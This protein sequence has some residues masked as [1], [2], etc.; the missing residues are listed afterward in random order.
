MIDNYL[1]RN[2]TPLGVVTKR[3]YTITLG[4]G[5]M[6]RLKQQTRLEQKKFKVRLNF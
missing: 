5:K 2:Y 3:D 4:N 6:Y 1:Q